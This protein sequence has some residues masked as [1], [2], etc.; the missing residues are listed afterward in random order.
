[1]P[2]HDWTLVDAGTFHAFH[3]GWITH[4]SE[5]MN[6]GLLPAGYYAMPEQHLGRSIGDVLTLH[7]GDLSSDAEPSGS[8]GGL[9]VATAP[10]QIQQRLVASAS[11][12]SRRRTLVVRHVTG[13]RIV[14]LVEIVSPANKDRRSHVDDLAIKIASSVGAGVNVLLV[15][16]LPP[17]AHDPSGLHGAVWQLLDPD[18]NRYVPPSDRLLTLAAYVAGAETEA[19][20]QPVG[21]GS[22]L[23]DMPLFLRTDRYVNL[24]LEKTYDAAFRGMPA[25]WRDVLEK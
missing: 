16:L 7:A 18:S 1:M 5:T 8:Q 23:P 11:A 14:A 21:V 19:Y 12:A 2:I 9:A 10:P 13:H 20:L 25:V 4:L 15:D 3:T 17:S 6:A 24:P 22:T